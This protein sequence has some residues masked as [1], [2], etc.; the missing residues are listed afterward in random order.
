MHS[1]STLVASLALLTLH[2]NSVASQDACPANCSITG[3]PQGYMAGWS[4]IE[5]GTTLTAATIIEIINTD[6]GTTRTTTIYNDNI[7]LPST[8]AQG[9]RT[10][11]VT[12]TRDGEVLTTKMLAN[13]H[14]DSQKSF[15]NALLSQCFPNQFLCH[16]PEM[17]MDRD[18]IDDHEQQ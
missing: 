9:T 3:V 16:S 4:A 10:Q 11:L 14:R 6:L 15:A 1:P 18:A 17:A 13:S 7:R 8:N 12:Y 2:I 5:T